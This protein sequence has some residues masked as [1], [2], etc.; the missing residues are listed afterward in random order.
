MLL[1]ACDMEVDRISNHER[2]D[3]YHNML[4][5]SGKAMQFRK[6][7]RP[8][9]LIEIVRSSSLHLLADNP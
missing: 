5:F 8:L 9:V 3:L 6:I 2:L 4:Y 1:D 7:R